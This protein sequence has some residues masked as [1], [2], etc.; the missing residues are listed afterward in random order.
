MYVDST[1]RLPKKGLYFHNFLTGLFRNGRPHKRL[2]I[3]YITL[4]GY[5]QVTLTR[6]NKEKKGR[7][8]T[9]LCCVNGGFSF[10]SH[11]WLLIQ[12]CFFKLIKNLCNFLLYFFI[13]YV[14][15]NYKFVLISAISTYEL[16]PNVKLYSEFFL[17]SFLKTINSSS[18]TK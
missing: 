1:T 3:L 4:P 15:Q 13:T 14:M 6:G 2:L 18:F 12:L 10:S 16:S 9:T 7:G 5:W 8:R 17:Y 11:C